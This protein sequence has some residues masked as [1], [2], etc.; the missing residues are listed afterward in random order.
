MTCC[1]DD[2]TFVGFV[3]KYD[4]LDTLEQRSWIDVTAKVNVKYHPLYR[5]EGPVLTAL[6][7]HPAQPA[8]EDIVYFS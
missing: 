8:A 6:E 4:R 1:V 3:C 2:I 7:I 5:G